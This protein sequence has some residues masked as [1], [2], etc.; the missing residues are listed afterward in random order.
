VPRATRYVATFVCPSFKEPFAVAPLPSLSVTIRNL[1]IAATPPRPSRV[2]ARSESGVVVRV[3]L[4]R[5][6]KW[7]IKRHLRTIRH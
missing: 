4:Y 6:G 5:I 2:G 7:P 1:C 3:G